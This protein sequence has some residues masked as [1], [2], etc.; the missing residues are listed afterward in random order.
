MDGNGRWAEGRGRPRTD[1]HAAGAEVVRQIVRSAPAF[2][3]SALTLYAFSSDNWRRPRAEVAALLALFVRYL[4]EETV[5]CRDSGVRLTAIGRRDRLPLPLRGALAAA[6]RATRGGTRL[7]LRLA[8]DYSARDE[9][10]R[11]AAQLSHSATVRS[12]NQPEISRARFQAA[13]GGGPDLDLLIRTG[14]ERRLSDFLLWEAAYAE[15]VFVEKPWPAFG[16]GELEAAV[17]EFHRRDRR[18]GQVAEGRGA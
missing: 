13:L 9:I 1:G 3:I 5:R 14:G 12:R 15:L 16:T 10:L 8:I 7:W 18:F 11:A 17:A 4:R 2:G 6:E